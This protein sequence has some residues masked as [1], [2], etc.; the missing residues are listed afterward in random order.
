MT[1]VTFTFH[2][3]LA[4]LLKKKHRADTTFQHRFD[5]KASIKDVIE[6]LG[7]PHPVVGEL[8]VNGRNVGFDH[9][10]HHGDMVAAY[11]L[12]P[13]ANPMLP[14]ILRPE[15]LDRIAFV[16]D[17][18][19]GKLAL[20]LRM[21]GFDT[22]YANDLRN[23]RLAEIAASEKRLLLTRD[24]S[25]LKRKVV[26]HGYLVQQQDPVRQLIEVVR[27]Y[28]LGGKIKPLTRCI[29]CNGLLVT[30]AKENILERLEPLTRK[31]YDSFKICRECGKIYWAG[32]HQE[33]IN[34]FI[35]KVLE[36]A[37]YC[38]DTAGSAAGGRSPGPP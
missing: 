2:G 1:V 33:K 31:Y 5:R 37:G 7:V 23:G 13:P 17:V 32:S 24:T 10:L 26:R 12:K 27:L 19:V 18:N 22:I 6:S 15:P 21:L 38:P 34:A 16:V 29:V 20:Y 8:L 4:K 3:F 25:L 14:T 28:D 9:I 11:P 36:A 35:R 30:V